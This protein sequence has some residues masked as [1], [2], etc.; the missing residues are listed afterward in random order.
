MIEATAAGAA[1]TIHIGRQPVYD[2]EGRL[3]GYELLFRPAISASGSGVD[4]STGP[5][6]DVATSSTILAAFSDF[7]SAELLGGRLGF[8][9]LTRGFIVGNLPLPFE[10]D[11]VVLEILETVSVDQEVVDGVRG[12]CDRGFRI[13]LDDFTWSA[14]AE[15]LLE[16]VHLVKIDVLGLPWEQVMATVERCRPHGVRLLA[17]RVEDEETLRRCVTAGFELFQGYHLGRPQTLTAEGLTPNQAVALRLV[18]ALG[19][20]GTSAP[21]VEKLMSQDAAL[22]YRLLRI[23]NSAAYARPRPLSRLRDAVVLVGMARLRAW[24]VLATMEAG[25]GTGAGLTD[26]IVL[27]R[28]CEI[29]TRATSATIAPETAFTLGLLHG[30]VTGLG[31]TTDDLVRGMPALD[32]RLEAALLDGDAASTGPDPVVAELR[33]VLDAVL[34]YLDGSLPTWP[35]G[36]VLTGAYLEALAWAETTRRGVSSPQEH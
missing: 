17:E 29:V 34:T 13:A 33:R 25:G 27:A 8:I 21:D 32:P 35:D 24:L 28:T 30:L 1:R 20:P 7:S 16:L 11:G 14:A 12:L 19:D 5:E 9:N 26:A 31:T 15:P 4:G 22:T 10:P 18:A 2:L 23:A 3:Y 6:A 36:D